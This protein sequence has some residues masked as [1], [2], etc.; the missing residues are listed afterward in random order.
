MY[1]NERYFIRKRF[2]RKGAG[3]LFVKRRRT[4]HSRRQ[5]NIQYS[6]GLP[7]SADFDVNDSYYDM[8]MALLVNV[9]TAAAARLDKQESA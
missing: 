5:I 4:S 1:S 8:F 3:F 2:F 6:G 9:T 7:L